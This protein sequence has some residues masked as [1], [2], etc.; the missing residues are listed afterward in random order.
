MFDEVAPE[1]IKSI[2]VIHICDVG[3]NDDGI[4]KNI[5]P[6]FFLVDRPASGSNILYTK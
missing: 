1:I 3:H 6:I 5:A 4:C 2:H